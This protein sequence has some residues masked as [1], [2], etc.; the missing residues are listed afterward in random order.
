MSSHEQ[1]PIPVIIDTD[2][3][4][5]DAIA[6]MLAFSHPET[7]DVRLIT[8][9]GGN[10]SLDKTTRNC[11]IVEGFLH[12][13]VPI[14][15]GMASPEA[16]P[17]EDVHGTN[18]LGI[19]DP[20]EYA[21]QWVPSPDTASLL[22]DL[23]A[24]DAQAE[25]LRTS[26]IPVT[27]VALGPLTNVALLLHVHP[28]LHDRICRIVLMGGAIGRGNKGP[29]TEFNIGSDPDA[30][31]RVL[32]SGIPLVMLP[33]EV[34]DAVTL[35]P[36][37]LD[38]LSV[39]NPVGEAMVTLMTASGDGDHKQGVKAL[40]DP[41]TIAYLCRPDLFTAERHRVEVELAGTFTR[42]ATVVFDNPTDGAGLPMEP[43]DGVLVCTMVATCDDGTSEHGYTG[44]ARWLFESVHHWDGRPV[45]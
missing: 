1:M 30:A 37:T 20:W 33:L 9:V 40:Y 10:V 41:T 14:A 42:G 36:A 28:E 6:L 4:V 32:S 19:D 13:H 27:I 43:A 22:M 44:F 8:S 16:A 38:G 17:A 35:R 3:G 24:V 25:V 39:L 18:G 2:P 11:Q 12:T 5:D 31:A 34:A 23:P 7:I 26:P 29:Y 45:G 21:R 15:R